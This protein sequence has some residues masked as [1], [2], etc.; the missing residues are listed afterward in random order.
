MP[1]TIYA[2]LV[3]INQYPPGVPSLHGCVNDIV[4]LRETLAAR[5]AASDVAFEPLVLTDAQA[6]RQ[7]LID[8]FRQHLGRAGPGDVA[9]F[10]YSGHGSQ[11]PS[12][13]EWRHLEPDG[14]DETL[15]CYDSR[16][17]KSWDLADKELAQLIAGLAANGP[18]VTVVLDCC[19]SGTGTRIAA[20]DS[21]VARRAPTDT[22]QRPASTFLLSPQEAT[23]FALSTG[24][25]TLQTGGWFA[26]PGGRHVVLSACRADETARELTLGGEQRGV[27]SFYLLETLKRAGTAL[28]CRDLFKRASALVR[29]TVAE[30]SPQ[31]EATVVGDLDQPFLGAGGASRATYTVSYDRE[32][33]WVLD[34]GAVNGLPAPLGDECVWLALFPFDADLADLTTLAGAVGAARI[35]RVFPTRSTVAITMHEG[36]TADPRTS[37]KALVTALPL[38]PLPIAFTGDTAALD[39]ARDALAHA[40]PTG[41]P[42]LLVRESDP[43]EAACFLHAQNGAYRIQRSGDGYPLVV[44]TPGFHPEGARLAV[45]RLEHIARWRQTVELS[46]PASQLAPGAVRLEV[47]LPDAQGQWQPVQ[48]GNPIALAYTWQAGEWRQP[49]FKLRLTNTSR[50]RLYC[51]LFDLPESYGIF[52]LIPGGGCWLGPGETFWANNG[53]P[54]YASVPEN[55]WQQGI[56]TLKDTLKLIVTTAESDGT[57]LEQPDLPVAALGARSAPPLPQMHTLNRLMYRMG[58]RH[59]GPEPERNAAFTDWVTDELSFSTTRPLAAVALPAA[60]S[61]VEPGPSVNVAGHPQLKGRLRLSSL[62]ALGRDAGNLVLPALLRNHPEAFE[63]FVF[64]ASRAGEPGPS[65]L[66]LDEVEDHTVVTPAE[67]LVV[68]I[69]QP[70]APDEALLPLGYDGELYLPL[71]RV[72]RDDSGVTV[73]LERLPAPTSGG[74]RDLKGS[75]KI[76]FQKLVGQRLGWPYAHPLLAIASVGADGTVT[77]D[78]DPDAV[79]AA[80]QR[81][82][83]ILLYVHG[84]IG[85]TRGLAASARPEWL[86]LPEAVPALAER[87]DLI[88]TYDYENLH[89]SIEE[90]ARLLKQRLNAA[91]LSPGHRKTLDIVAHSMGG[92]VA[93]WLI[94]REDGNQ[95][96]HR[97]V[98]LGT[99]NAGSPWPTVQDFAV[100]ALGIGLNALAKLV[101]PIRIIGL[102]VSVIEQ[103]DVTLD[104][105]RPGSDF[106]KTLAASP[107]PGVPYAILAGNTTLLPH[108]LEPEGTKP[109]LIERLLA[110][111]APEQ[112]WRNVTA[113]AF[114]GQP[115]DTAVSVASIS[116]VPQGRTPAPLVREVASDHLMYFSTVAG[117]RALAEAIEAEA[118]VNR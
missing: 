64:G 17:R 49:Q 87:Y 10:Y 59:I 81:A 4:H 13:P 101:W 7:A 117:L 6:T 73:R 113:L 72:T 114:F 25:D 80:V 48:P 66:E 9:L 93:R 91:G 33:G 41:G 110:R 47:L 69:D 24:R 86:H 116:S 50:R 26:L 118:G 95:L 106:L 42:S 77:Y 11:A 12:P 100:V 14:L 58:F 55:L 30:Q 112:L 107:D 62:S 78:P 51:M 19:H 102:L 22:R 43:A 70:L 45:E 105:M 98:L 82:T 38:L 109:A 56:T 2:L 97:L 5:F 36:V 74:E 75:I 61:T 1:R 54:F 88:L 3:G 60:G 65:V 28:S 68:R 34:G 40:G 32:A 27:F 16:T 20:E 44:A 90:N 76:L 67:P 23:A 104:Q 79:R 8:G 71:G 92:L 111:L 21:A 37:Y 46:N 99:P 115:N 15:V 35:T 83:R 89:T 29:A 94:E 96:V 31:I 85:D 108:A 84:I 103:V 63:P 39:L 53:E 57:L 52:S 18:Q